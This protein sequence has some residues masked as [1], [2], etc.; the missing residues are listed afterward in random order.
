MRATTSNEYVT[1]ANGE[2]DRSALEPGAYSVEEITAPDGYVIDNAIRTIQLNPGES[3]QFVFTNTRKPS[4]IIWKYDLQTA[5]PLPDTEFS[6]AK[7]GGGV[8]YESLTNGSGFIRLENLD[9]GW[10][11]VTEMA[12]AP[13]YLNSVPGTSFWLA[14]TIRR[15]ALK[16]CRCPR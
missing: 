14:A 15:C 10:Y 5:Q 13:G 3:A 7:K 4:L 12:P 6:I 1:D 8:I 2:I 16:M 9:E 11:T